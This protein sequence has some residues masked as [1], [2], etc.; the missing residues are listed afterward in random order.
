LLELGLLVRNW[1]GVGLLSGGVGKHF[2]FFLVL[3]EGSLVGVIDS[4]EGVLRVAFAV[5]K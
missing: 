5:S 3:K 4:I 1:A 2:G